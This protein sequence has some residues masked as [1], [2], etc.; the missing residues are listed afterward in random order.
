MFN[1]IIGLSIALFLSLVGNYALYNKSVAQK[2]ELN[3]LSKNNDELN[4]RIIFNAGTLAKTN[5]SFDSVI[6]K[7]DVLHDSF[8][9]LNKDLSNVDCI[10]PE[11]VMENKNEK[12]LSKDNKKSESPIVDNYYRILHSAYRLQDQ[13]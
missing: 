4:Q 7:T 3:V 5:N 2:F 13:N 6:K 9:S 12:Q 1:T 11:V 10:K 8:A